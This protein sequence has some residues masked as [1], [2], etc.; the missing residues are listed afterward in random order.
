MGD[1]REGIAARRVRPHQEGF[2]GA[3]IAR[4]QD[5]QRFLDERIVRARPGYA[6]DQQADNKNNAP[7]VHA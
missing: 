1:E 2:E 6:G 4:Q 3:E 7:P 5:A